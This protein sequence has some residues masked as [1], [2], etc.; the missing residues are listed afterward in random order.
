MQVLGCIKLSKLTR[1]DASF[2]P[3]GVRTSHVHTQACAHARMYQI[4]GFTVQFTVPRNE[5]FKSRL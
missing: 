5:M 2:L 1:M 3:R 4:S